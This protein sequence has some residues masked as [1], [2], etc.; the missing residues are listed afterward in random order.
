[1]APVRKGS[2]L[3][4]TR[5][6]YDMNSYFK[7]TDER[8]KRYHFCHC[9][10]ARTSILIDEGTVSKTMCYCSLGFVIS[11]WEETLGVRLHGDVVESVLGGDDI[12]RFVIYLPDEVV[13]KYT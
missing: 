12:C 13:E 11:S 9:L 8:K 4:I 5:H 3:H 10:F 7:E 6:P 2:E 1:M